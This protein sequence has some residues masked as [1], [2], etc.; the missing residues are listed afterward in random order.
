MNVSTV[1]IK[2]SLLFLLLFCFALFLFIIVRRLI[3]ERIDREKQ[4]LNSIIEQ[5]VLDAI[6]AES[7]AE[8]V[9]V[10]KKYRLFPGTLTQV[11]IRFA[12]NVE[13]Q[14]K[15]RLKIIFETSLRKRYLKDLRSWSIVKRL[16]TIRLFVLMAAPSDSPLLIDLLNDKP[17]V[18]LSVIQA[19]SRLPSLRNISYIFD[20]FEKDSIPQARTYSNIMFGLGLK[21]ESFVSEYIN[22]PLPAEKLA[23]LIELAGSI[24][25]RAL[26]DQIGGFSYHPNKEIRIAVARALGNLRIPEAREELV[27]LTEDK[28]WEV[29]A[30]AYKSLGKLKLNDSPG[31]LE[32][33][34][35][36]L[37]WHVRFNAG[38]SLAKL[39]SAGIDRL[40]A[41]AGE[42]KDRFASD[43]AVMVL[44]SIFYTEE[45]P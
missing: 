18:R 12:E 7:E 10:G 41:I 13:G 5:D 21:I 17:L 20:A 28:E 24:P 22:H 38:Y 26:Y 1:V 32:K 31:V 29:Q 27:R 37:N 19:L 23:L 44:D 2:F 25:L 33:G 39:G 6:Y 8:S 36:S 35:Y 45:F 14:A 4:K 42:H 30:Q 11:L 40:K 15:D 3:V 16:R 9:A 34:L 43:M